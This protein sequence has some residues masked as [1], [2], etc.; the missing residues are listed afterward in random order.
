MVM[1]LTSMFNVSMAAGL[2]GGAFGGVCWADRV[3]AAAR[4]VVQTNRRFMAMF[5]LR[6]ERLLLLG[7]P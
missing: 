4:S 1:V 5:F 7:W 2:F 6:A 3:A